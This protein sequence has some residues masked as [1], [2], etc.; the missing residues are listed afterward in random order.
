MG[1]FKLRLGGNEM[2]SRVAPFLQ[3]PGS[4]ITV[5]SF[6]ARSFIDICMQKGWREEKRE[7]AK[8]GTREGGSNCDQFKLESVFTHIRPDS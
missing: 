3:L 8:E 6:Q 7:T 4:S 2:L 5:F 1:G